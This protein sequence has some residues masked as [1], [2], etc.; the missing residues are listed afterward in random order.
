MRRRLH[1]LAWV[2]LL[3]GV[4]FASCLARRDEPF[5]RQTD[6]DA[7]PPDAIAVDGSARDAAPDPL[8]IAPHAVLGVDPP[9][10]PFK[11]GTHVTIRG[12]GFAG[13]TRVWF[14]DVEVPRSKIT[15][16]DP[17]RLQ[18]D[19]PPAAA[20]IVDVRVQNGNAASTGASLSGGFTYDPFYADPADGPTSGGTI[21]TIKGDDTDW[22]DR[23]AVEIDRQPCTDVVVVSPQELQCTTPPGDFGAKVLSVRTGEDAEDVLDGFSYGNSDNG[24]RGGFSGDPLDDELTVLAFDNFEGRALPGVAVLLGDS[25]ETGQVK[26][27]DRNGVATFTGDLG[28]DPV[29]TLALKCFQ[30]I[31]FYDVEADHLTAYLDPVLSPA[32]ADLGGDLPPGGGNPRTYAGV[33]GEVMWPLDKELKRRGWSNVPLPASESE[34]QVAYVFRLWDR[35]DVP[36]NLP[37]SGAVTRDSVGSIGYRFNDIYWP[38]CLAYSGSSCIRQSADDPGNFTLYALAGIQNSATNPPK[39]TAYAMGILPGVAVQPRQTLSDVYIQIDV[40]LD[41]ALSFELEP[42]TPGPRG[43]DRIRASVAIQIEDQGYALLPAGSVAQPLPGANHFSFVG[44][45]PLVGSLSGAQYLLS[46]RAVTGAQE[47]EPLS[48]LG[49][50]VTQSSSNVPNIGAFVPVPFLTEPAANQTWD[51]G[52]IVLETAPSAVP[53]D[54]TVV[55]VLAGDGLYEWTVVGKG[56]RDEFDLP[57]LKALAPDAALPHG[58]LTIVPT[59][60]YVREDFDYRKLRYRELTTRGW[61]SYASDTFY[62]QY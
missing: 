8:D 22:D 25:P 46:A 56:D 18:L 20:G 15:P 35:P 38:R 9:H 29:V 34:S 16:L 44:I 26:Y 4:F 3:S 5:V 11:G 36:F 24:F 7:G 2:G 54:L 51:F 47:D 17:Q 37:T 50:F 58:S 49:T 39:F 13:N 43:P 62:T 40:P 31:T 32:C 45:P 30:P 48:V 57:D 23:T 55:R 12:N 21:I 19:T 1:A 14:G 53:V 41:H 33:T 42:P 28:T 6:D 59:R 60:A 10:G 52:S 61:M 27:T